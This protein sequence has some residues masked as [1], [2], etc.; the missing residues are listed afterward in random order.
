MHPF[1]SH[2][3][4]PFIAAPT[5]CADLSLLSPNLHPFI[6][7]PLTP[8]P[9]R[10][11]L[12][13]LI[14]PF[15]TAPPIPSL[16]LMLPFSASSHSPPLHHCHPPFMTAP[17]CFPSTGRPPIPSAHL[18]P[19]PPISCPSRYE[20]ITQPSKTHTPARRSGT[21]GGRGTR[22][23]RRGATPRRTCAPQNTSAAPSLAAA[24]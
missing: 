24:C 8:P 3:C 12:P 2:H 6:T 7:A 21:Q 20:Y 15:I 16:R 5:P 14:A 17:P 13:L 10:L 9:L 11:L 23:G 4:P 1:A 22:Q 19:F 18:T